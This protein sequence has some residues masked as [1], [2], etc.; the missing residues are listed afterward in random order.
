MTKG[1]FYA[2]TLAAVLKFLELP[3]LVA[4]SI[5]EVPI[6]SASDASAIRLAVDRSYR[7]RFSDVDI[8]LTVRL[9]PAECEREGWLYADCLER[10]GFTGDILGVHCERTEDRGEVIR[11]CKANG[12]RYD[13]VVTPVAAEDAERLPHNDSPRGWMEINDFW[14]VAVQALGKLMR[15]DYL[16]SSHLAHELAQRTLVLQMQIRDEEKG[17]TFHRYGYQEDVEYLKQWGDLHGRCPAAADPVF[18]HIWELLFA[19]AASFDRLCARMGGA[20]APRFGLFESIWEE[21]RK[22]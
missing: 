22:A 10:L 8:K 20:Y 6:S 16:I 1:R 9:N 12:M 5:K 3:E 19:A 18:A 4:L 7:D 13:L 15:G 17:T 11:I 14:F 21:Y 2:E